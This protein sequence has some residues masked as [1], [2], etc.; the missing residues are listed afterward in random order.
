LGWLIRGDRYWPSREARVRKRHGPPLAADAVAKALFAPRLPTIK[1]DKL[2][3]VGPAYVREYSW[4]GRPASAISTALR[5]NT[6]DSPASRAAAAGVALLREPLR[7]PP[8]LP[9]RPLSSGRPR[10]R[11]G[12]FSEMSSVMVAFYCPTEG[13]QQAARSGIPWNE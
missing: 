9:D 4:A 7:R 8:G 2:G 3:E 1:P 6:R 11:A 10:N 12:S 5:V 13:T